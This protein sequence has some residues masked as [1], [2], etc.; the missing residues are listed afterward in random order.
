MRRLLASLLLLLTLSAADAQII[1]SLPVTLTNGT[2]ADASQVMQDFN[3]IVSQTNANAATAGANSNITALTG[4]TTPL[5]PGQ[6]G[7]QLY[8]AGTSTGTANA[9]VVS[10][11][12][13]PAGFALTGKSTICFIAG[14]TNTGATTLNVN[15]TGVTNVFKRSTSGP[16][17]LIGGEIVINNLVCVQY[18]GTQYELV[19]DNKKELG[20]QVSL[21]SSGTTD[22]GTAATNNVLVTGTT[23]ITSFGSTAQTDLPIYFLQFNNTLTLTYNATS[24]IL[25]GSENIVTANGDTAIAQYLGSGNWRIV[26]YQKIAAPQPSIG[27]ALPGV[28]GLTIANNAGTPS[29]K[30]DISDTTAI[31]TNSSNY[32]TVIGNVSCTINLSTTGLNGL[33][34]G[35]VSASTWYYLYIITNNVTSGCLASTSSTSPTMPAGY[36]YKLRVGAMST[37]GSNNLFRS[38]QNGKTGFYVIV[39]ATNTATYPNTSIGN[40]ASSWTLKNVAGLCPSTAIAS[41]VMGNATGSI[42]S[43]AVGANAAEAA[44]ALRK[45]T[46]QTTGTYN[47]D[48][49]DH[50]VEFIDNNVYFQ[51]STAA[52]TARLIGWTDSVNAN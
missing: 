47:A 10:S 4:L 16:I 34:T 11:G 52:A 31:L 30:I 20:K 8:T 18:D 19:D 26:A 22:L 3:Y 42:T 51:A 14:A 23:T 17:A 29:A 1:G 7:S 13:T 5:T 45:I 21:A 36:T 28:N 12:I 41:K 43:V 25:P 9:Q 33:D 44:L 39:A 2:V 32:A 27:F 49:G 38:Q 48:T 40:G 6:G 37:D 24:L 35:S 15:S 50:I 46:S